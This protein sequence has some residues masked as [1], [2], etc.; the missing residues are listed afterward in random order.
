M[1]LSRISE[2]R[3]DCLDINVDMSERRGLAAPV[4][5]DSLYLVSEREDPLGMNH[6]LRCL[7]EG[8]G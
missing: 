1:G 3:L 8:V 4:A 6:A 5:W 2:D 7:V